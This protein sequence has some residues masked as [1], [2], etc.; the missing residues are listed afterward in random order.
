[1]R[2]ADFPQSQV[3][4]AVYTASVPSPEERRRSLQEA[5][6]IGLIALSGLMAFWVG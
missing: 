3:K 2:H 5:I 1:M 4:V 6:G